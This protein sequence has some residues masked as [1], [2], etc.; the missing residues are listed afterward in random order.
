LPNC[1]SKTIITIP[2]KISR[3]SIILS[4]QHHQTQALF[5]TLFIPI[6]TS[7]SSPSS[8]LPLSFPLSR[9]RFQSKKP[10]LLSS[11]EAFA[12]FKAHKT[13]TAAFLKIAVQPPLKKGLTG[14]PFSDACPTRGLQGTSTNK[15]STSAANL[16][17]PMPFTS[18]SGGRL[19]VCAKASLGGKEI[20]G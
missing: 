1:R 11:L 5:N 15:V 4:I 20:E 3:Q 10:H 13:S 7:C 8:F 9:Q 19:C 6:Q 2:A 16:R 17:A 18:G 14:A 12:L